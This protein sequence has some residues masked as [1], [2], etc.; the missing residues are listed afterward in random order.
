[1]NR[2]AICDSPAETKFCVNFVECNARARARLGIPAWQIKR[3]RG[4]DEFR[5]A[6]A[7][8]GRR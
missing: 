6:K 7:H 4:R 5:Y 3:E 2:C 1:M 8:G